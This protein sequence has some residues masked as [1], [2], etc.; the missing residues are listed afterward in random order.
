LINSKKTV[1]FTTIVMFIS[2]T[3]ILSHS[4]FYLDDW[5]WGKWLIGSTSDYGGRFIGNFFEIILA[6]SHNQVFNGV[7]KS[8]VLTF[9]CIMVCL[10]SRK[11]NVSRILL[12]NSLFLLSNM[13]IIY[14]SFIWTAGFVNYTLPFVF[15]LPVVLINQ[16]LKKQNYTKQYTIIIQLISLICIFASGFF[17]ETL[18]TTMIFY[19]GTELILNIYIYKTKKI[20]YSLLAVI[21]SIVSFRIM[22]QYSERFTINSSGYT[23]PSFNSFSDLIENIRDVNTIIIINLFH[24]IFILVLI[25][26]LFITFI[27]ILLKLKTKKNKTTIYIIQTILISLCPTYQ[28]II[29]RPNLIYDRLFFPSV[30]ILIVSGMILYGFIE[31]NIANKKT[32]KK[33]VGFIFIC[34]LIFPTLFFIDMAKWNDNIHSANEKAIIQQTDIEY[35][36]IKPQYHTYYY[37]DAN[38]PLLGQNW[39]KQYKIYYNIPNE[40]NI[41]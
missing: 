5:S 27:I 20:I 38:G 17:L 26:V 28:L 9:I 23:I 19:L 7:F 37:S 35:S 10:I 39:I 31:N 8:L 22:M 18:S 34:S 21:T 15:V 25:A 36:K 30:M 2:W 29:L 11:V 6:A 4:P 14:Q 16:K 3:I 32:L 33:F 12:F 13:S 40:V 1:L 41:K 24:N